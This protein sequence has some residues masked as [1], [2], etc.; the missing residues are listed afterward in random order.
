VPAAPPREVPE[1]RRTKGTSAQ[2]NAPQR[3]TSVTGSG[4]VLGGMGTVYSLRTGRYYNAAA[5]HESP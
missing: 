2:L 3:T 1:T 5:D 4:D